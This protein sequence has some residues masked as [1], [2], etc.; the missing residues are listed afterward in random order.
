MHLSIIKKSTEVYQ[1]ILFF[2]LREFESDYYYRCCCYYYYYYYEDD[3]DDNVVAEPENSKK[4][5]LA[6]GG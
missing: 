2:V 5:P 4:I 3:D 6:K 1:Y